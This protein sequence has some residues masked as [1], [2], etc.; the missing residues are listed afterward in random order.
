MVQLCGI[1][2]MG[3]RK[4]GV[5][6]MGRGREVG[7]VDYRKREVGVNEDQLGGG[8]LGIVGRVEGGG[9]RLKAGGVNGRALFGEL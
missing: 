6:E 5:E 9:T 7:V 8:G 2:H 4:K 3:I 1:V